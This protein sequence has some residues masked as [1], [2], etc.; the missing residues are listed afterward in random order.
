MRHVVSGRDHHIPVGAGRFLQLLRH[1]LDE[2]EIRIGLARTVR[3]DLSRL[4]QLHDFGGRHID[5]LGRLALKLMLH[6]VLEAL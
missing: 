6:E 2:A 3:V 5:V 1:V 4:V